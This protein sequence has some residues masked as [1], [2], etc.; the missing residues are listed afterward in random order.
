[1]IT[2][3]WCERPATEMVDGFAVCIRGGRDDHSLLADLLAVLAPSPTQEPLASSPEAPGGQSGDL[4]ATGRAI[5]ARAARGMAQRVGLGPVFVPREYVSFED[6]C[7]AGLI[8]LQSAGWQILPPD[9]SASEQDVRH[10]ALHHVGRA[11]FVGRHPMM[12]RPAGMSPL[13]Y[14]VYEAGYRYYTET[15]PGLGGAV[16]R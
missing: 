13:D 7:C 4:G 10:E 6:A 15:V 1:M 9:E 12:E 5:L 2:C 11:D 3:F 8:A 16:G 14:R